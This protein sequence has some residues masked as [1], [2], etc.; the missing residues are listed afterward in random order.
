MPAERLGGGR[1]H[2]PVEVMLSSSAHGFP[3]SGVA[4]SKAEQSLDGLHPQVRAGIA[5]EEAHDIRYNIS[6]AEFRR[7][8]RLTRDRMQGRV[9]NEVHRVTQCLGEHRGRGFVRV[10]IEEEQTLPAGKRVRVVERRGLQVSERRL[11]QQ[12]GLL[13]GGR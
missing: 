13:L 10:V 6:D 3:S 2:D 7:P 9:A 4:A 11:L 1:S 12:P 5:L 8:T